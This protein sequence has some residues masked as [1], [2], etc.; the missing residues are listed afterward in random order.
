MAPNFFRM[1][2][3]LA[4]AFAFLPADS[5]AGQNLVP[6]AA[7]DSVAVLGGQDCADG[8]VK[9]DGT[10]ETG[11]GWVPS[12]VDGRYVQRFEV[13]EFRS[14]KMEEVC[15]CWTHTHPNDE[16][17][18]TVQMYRD[19]GGSPARSPHASIEA[20]VSLVPTFPDG[21]FYSVDVSEADFHAQTPTFYIGVQ[22]NP[23]EDGFF[24]VCVDQSD[25]TPVVDGW[26]VDD[27]AEEWASVL[28]SNDPIFDDHRAMMIRAKALEGYY[29]Y[30]P[31]LGTWGLLVL[32]AAICA[33]GA[34]VLRRGERGE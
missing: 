24:F 20:V 17:R 32:V 28:E 29:P 21:A 7:G 12:V 19:R 27:R 22:W 13:D 15:I 9:D 2:W 25:T 4:L 31:T 11:Y 5:S 16:I 14:Q 8:V 10:L 6:P 3:L 33:V 34:L 23:S 26:F 30:V 1:L 18:F